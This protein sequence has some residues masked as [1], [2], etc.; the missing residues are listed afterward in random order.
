MALIGGV[1]ALLVNSYQVGFTKMLGA[2]FNDVWGGIAF[3]LE[4]G[5][6]TGSGWSIT[7]IIRIITLTY[8]D[9]ML[10]KK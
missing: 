7:I 4:S 3:C 8:K 10:K 6:E 1:L 5:F 2:F 9:M